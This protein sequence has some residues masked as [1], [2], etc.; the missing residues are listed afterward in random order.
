MPY[1]QDCGTFNSTTDCNVCMRNSE[2]LREFEEED[3]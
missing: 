2:A 1:C 3:D